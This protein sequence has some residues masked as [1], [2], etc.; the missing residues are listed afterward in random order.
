M[1]VVNHH[2]VVTDLCHDTG[3]IWGAEAA[4]NSNS[5]V[6]LSE[7]AFDGV[8]DHGQIAF[9]RRV[10]Y[11]DAERYVLGASPSIKDL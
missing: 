9:L 6:A 1:L 8:C 7:F 4:S 10:K 5:Y 3:Y 2:K 11:I